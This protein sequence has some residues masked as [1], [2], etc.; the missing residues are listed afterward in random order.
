MAKHM[1]KCPIC[2]QTFDANVEPYVMINSRRYAHQKCQQEAE[3]LKSKEEKDKEQLE[4]YIK[5]LFS[6]SKLPEKVNRQIKQY[7]E[8]FNYSYSAIY[9]TLRYWF[10]IKNGD[11][12]KANGGIGI[13]PYVIDDAR[14]YWI[15]I[16]QAKELNKELVQ[17][18]IELKVVEVHILPPERIPVR[19]FRRKF[20]FLEEG[21]NEQ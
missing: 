20:T 11:L 6:Y 15:D 17:Q 2:G 4:T 16:L 14:N 9:K 21:N 1:V 19:R 3:L 5:K 13:V 18:N 12:E 8:E 10:E 7:K